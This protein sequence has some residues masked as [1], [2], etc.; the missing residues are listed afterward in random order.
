MARDNKTDTMPEPE[1][2]NQVYYYAAGGNTLIALEKGEASMKSKARLGGFG[3][4]S[5]GYIING[6]QSPVRIK[7]SETISFIVKMETMM[8]DPSNTLIL[9]KLLPK[10]NNRQALLQQTGF[11]GKTN[12]QNQR[13]IKYNLKKS[14]T[15]VYT[16]LPERPLGPGEYAFINMLMPSSYSGTSPSYTVFAFGID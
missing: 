13:G 2:M 8:M 9:Y 4:S 3:G 15:G 11:M 1:Y 12:S 10:G 6:S 7:N 5:S 14:S 16:I